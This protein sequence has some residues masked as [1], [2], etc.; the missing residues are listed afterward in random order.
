MRLVPGL[1][2]R[3]AR[4][5][6]KVCQAVSGTRF[7]S[8]PAAPGRRTIEAQSFSGRSVAISGAAPAPAATH[9][10]YVGA[11]RPLVGVGIGAVH[12]CRGPPRPRRRSSS[13]A[14]DRPGP[15]PLFPARVYPPLSAAL[16]TMRGIPIDIAARYHGFLALSSLRCGPGVDPFPLRWIDRGPAARCLPVRPAFGRRLDRGSIQGEGSN[17]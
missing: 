10:S 17:V 8:P 1:L 4:G 9:R 5:A 12:R 6:A 13:A 7:P 2:F 15:R 16:E 14:R 3:S 11:G